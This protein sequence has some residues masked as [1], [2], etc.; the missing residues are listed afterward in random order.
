MASSFEDLADRCESSIAALKRLAKQLDQGEGIDAK[1]VQLEATR[2][3][4]D[5]DQTMKAINR[6]VKG[7]PSSKRR[8]MADREAELAAALKEQ[9]DA[10]SRGA[11]K[12][13]RDA[14]LQK[15]DRAKEVAAAATDKLASAASRAAA[16]TQKLR[17]VTGMVSDTQDIGVGCAFAFS[18]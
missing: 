1:A 3:L 6:E 7:M 11:A 2:V 16:N 8:P 13:E 5:A 15:P 12:R 9:R 18:P 14:L 17:E 4:N 10:V